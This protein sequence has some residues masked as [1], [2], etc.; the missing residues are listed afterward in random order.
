MNIFCDFENGEKIDL[1][2]YAEY[3]TGVV[4]W[5]GYEEPESERE[6]RFHELGSVASIVDYETGQ[7]ILISNGRDQTALRVD[8]NGDE[9]SGTCHVG[10]RPEPL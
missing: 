5:G 8:D 6:V 1:A 3:G 9:T 10:F 2:V 7:L 4:F